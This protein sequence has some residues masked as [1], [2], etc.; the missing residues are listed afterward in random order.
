MRLL[1]LPIHFHASTQRLLACYAVVCFLAI[2]LTLA[3][4]PTVITYPP[5]AG[6]TAANDFR[7]WVN[8][9][10]IFLYNTVPAA[11]GQFS[12]DGEV[13]VRVSA[14]QDVKWVDFR[15]K[16][17]GISY[18]LKDNQITFKLSKPS[19]L[20]IEFHNESKRVIH[21]FAN[22]L[23]GP[24]PK[25]DDP[26]V[27]YFKAGKVY[28]AGVINLKEGDHLYIEGGAV[29]KGAVEAAHTKNIKISGRGIL[30]GTDLK[31]G[32]RMILLDRID[33]ASLEGIVL[34]NSHTWTVE[35][36]FCQHLSIDNLKIVNW[37]TGSDGIDL[38][39]TSHV[40]IKNC[41]VRAN[42][43]CIVVK[44]WNGADKYAQ[45]TGVGPD[46]E[47]IDV[48]HSVFWNMPWGNA[49]EIGFELRAKS[50]RNIT[51]SDCDIIHVERGA[52]MS[53]HNGDFATVSDIRFEDIRVEDARHK[54]IDLAVFYSQYS[55]DR[56]SDE[57][58]RRKAY[59]QG[60]WDGV[61]W[62]Q[63][64]EEAKHATHRGS[65]KNIIFKNIQIVEGPAPFSLISGYDDQH[66]VENVTIDNLTVY[67]MKVKTT[68][69][70]KLYTER[71]KAIT[72]K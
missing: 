59:K 6:V 69:Q 38:V 18:Q 9:Q 60:A 37:Q 40:K 16:S 20:S 42:D 56:P 70:G 29:V 41:F 39:G 32:T 3:K 31:K 28:E 57:E 36:L 54:L 21:L 67:G 1:S 4:T 62:V 66:A 24:K 34:L 10:E 12:F 19:P 49:L 58:T 43:D 35:P 27:T 5:P 45:Q 44:T 47:D 61:L 25:P 8:D 64:G 26:H 7:V 2:N 23:E 53:I 30:D 63:P 52:A 15:P 50:V 72:I 46:V 11:V 51:F 55:V 17:Q 22:P 13:T 71:A 48:T 68:Q 65:I 14:I 33:G